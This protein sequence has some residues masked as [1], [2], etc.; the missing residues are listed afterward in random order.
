MNTASLRQQS[1]INNQPSA[2]RGVF[3]DGPQSDQNHDG[4]E[5]PMWV[6]YIGDE[7]ANPTG[8]VYHVGSYAYAATLA[9]SMSRERNLE[10]IDE[11]MPA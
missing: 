2:W 4:D 1:T 7:D 8:T 10:L 3:F 9:R 5:I 6:V 11:A